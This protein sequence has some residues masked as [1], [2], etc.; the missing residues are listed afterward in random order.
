METEKKNITEE[1]L[2]AEF[3]KLYLEKGFTSKLGTKFAY[4]DGMY[5]DVT[6]YVEWKLNNLI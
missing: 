1:T 5:I 3:E 4:I 6:K 2:I